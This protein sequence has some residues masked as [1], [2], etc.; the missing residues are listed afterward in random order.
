MAFAVH[1]LTIVRVRKR[2]YN[3]RY[4]AIRT[5]RKGGC[6]WTGEGYGPTTTQPNF[7]IKLNTWNICKHKTLVRWTFQWI[8]WIHENFSKFKYLRTTTSMVHKTFI[9]QG[10]IWA[11]HVTMKTS[12]PWI[13]FFWGG[14]TSYCIP[15]LWMLIWFNSIF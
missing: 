5:V 7:W 13:S 8:T 14:I 11:F 9:L 3:R 6:L 2:R 1:G 10:N 12:F 15:L 4:I